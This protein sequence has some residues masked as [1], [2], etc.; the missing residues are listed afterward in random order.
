MASALAYMSQ[1]L[2]RKP[3]LS[4]ICTTRGV[5]QML[6]LVD[7]VITHPSTVVLDAVYN[8]KPVGI[9]NSSQQELSCLPRTETAN[10]ICA[11]L[12]DPSALRHAA[13][14]RARYGEISNNLDIAAHE[15]E[16]YIL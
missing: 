16:S 10:E 9:F 1:F 4:N 15:V 5:V 8:D 12:D 14:I 3:A 11:F 6:A 2:I 7:K 13:P